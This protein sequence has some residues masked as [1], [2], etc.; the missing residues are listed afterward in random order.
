MPNEIWI[1][2]HSVEELRSSA[3]LKTGAQILND[4]TYTKFTETG[5]G[6]EVTR[7]WRW[8]GGGGALV[9]HRDSLTSKMLWRE[10]SG[11]GCTGT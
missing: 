8:G 3:G 11:D 7:G 2:Q 10:N 4:S 6:I 1:T 9:F 5:N